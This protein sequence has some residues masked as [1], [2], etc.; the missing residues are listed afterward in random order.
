MNK[1]C[2]REIAEGQY[3]S[4]CGEKDMGQSAPA[5]C[6][7]CGGTLRLKEETPMTDKGLQV[8]AKDPGK[9]HFYISLVKSAFRIIGAIILIILGMATDQMMLAYGASM[10][11]AA[12][13]LG[14]AEE[15]V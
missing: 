11:F 7:D 13:V 8:A 6:R 15:L 3:W 10:F 9:G 4:Y 14:I 12:E 2:N 5:L 1:G